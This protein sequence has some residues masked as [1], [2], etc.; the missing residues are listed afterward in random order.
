[1]GAI[2]ATFATPGPHN[3]SHKRKALRKAEE[4]KYITSNLYK[5]QLDG[6]R[7]HA[8]LVGQLPVPVEGTA[9]G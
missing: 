4:K 9:K 5:L 6:L 7:V 2:C 8:C 1:M 3:F